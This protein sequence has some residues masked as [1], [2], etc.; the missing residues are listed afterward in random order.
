MAAKQKNPRR[1]EVAIGA[2]LDTRTIAEAALKAKVPE[3]TLK[4]WLAD[5]RFQGLFRQARR[6]VVE[7]AIG[8]LQQV[9][10]KAVDT[11]ERNLACGQPARSG[12]LWASLT[13]R[14]RQCNSSIWWSA[15]INWNSC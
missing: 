10:H 14:S 1:W 13:T 4:S 6:Q 3:R 2:L 8:R 5:P 12:R 15:L 11:L 9:T 7:G